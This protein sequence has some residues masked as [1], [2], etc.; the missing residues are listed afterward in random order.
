MQKFVISSG[1]FTPNGFSGFTNKGV[2]IHIFTRQIESIGYTKDGEPIKYPFYC[3]AEKKDYDGR[4]DANKEKILNPDG[5]WGIKDRLTATAI[6]KTIDSMGQ[7]F[8]DDATLELRINQMVND[9]VS[10]YAV[11]TESV[12][13]LASAF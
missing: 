3:L 13:A 9:A 1:N 11:T 5:T 12:G 2:R 7:T 4:L 8:V 6:F 10:S